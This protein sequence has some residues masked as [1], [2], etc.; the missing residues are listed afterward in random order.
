MIAYCM[1][2]HPLVVRMKQL[3]DE[4]AFGDLFQMSIWT[5]QLT[6]YPADHWRNIYPTGGGQFFSHGCHY[7]DLMLWILE[8]D[9]GYASGH[10]LGTP[11]I[12]RGKASLLV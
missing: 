2:F 5:E 10:Q 4:R 12:K 11:W 6:Q 1:R 9:R 3:I 7:I 8:T